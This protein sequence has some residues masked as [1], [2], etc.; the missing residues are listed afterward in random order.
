MAQ[1]SL[2]VP[3]HLHTWLDLGEG[4]SHPFREA[5]SRSLHQG[6]LCVRGATQVRRIKKKRKMP[7]SWTDHLAEDAEVFREEWE[8]AGEVLASLSSPSPPPASNPL[9]HHGSENPGI[10]GTSSARRLA[11]GSSEGWGTSWK[12]WWWSN[13]WAFAI[14]VRTVGF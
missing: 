6:S 11:K 1:S 3:H 14:W 12:W 2:V 8:H 5:W 9:S 4:V 13:G 10:M 7:M